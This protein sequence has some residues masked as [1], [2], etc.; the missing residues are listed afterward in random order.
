MPGMER[1]G[2]RRV[3]GRNER[4]SRG[5]D[6][7]NAFNNFKNIILLV[8]VETDHVVNADLNK[9]AV[10]SEKSG[11]FGELEHETEIAAQAGTKRVFMSLRIVPLV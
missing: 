7:S 6:G 1:G 11:E 2:G 4:S 8:T 10:P 9:V 5:R 3:S